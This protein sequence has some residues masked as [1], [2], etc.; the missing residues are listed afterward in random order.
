MG[1]IAAF[2][3]RLVAAA[4]PC[5]VIFAAALLFASGAADLA[6]SILRSEL[7]YLPAKAA[8]THYG[9]R[10]VK[11]GGAGSPAAPGITQA[12]TAAG[13]AMAAGLPGAR[14]RSILGGAPAGFV[15]IV[16]EVPRGYPLAH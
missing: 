14:P 2:A 16:S 5:R 4:M 3:W 8:L 1:G 11:I 7:Q 13:P 12:A 9:D 6:L 10:L 15:P